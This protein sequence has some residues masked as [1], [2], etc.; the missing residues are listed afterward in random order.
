MEVK[1][2]NIKAVANIHRNSE[3][4][5]GEYFNYFTDYMYEPGAVVQNSAI[6]FV[7]SCCISNIASGNSSIKFYDKISSTSANLDATEKG[8]EFVTTPIHIL[9]FYNAI[10][11]NGIM[12]QPKLVTEITNGKDTIQQFHS[13]KISSCSFSKEKAVTVKMNCQ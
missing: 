11:N 4:I 9:A 10:A 3:G 2:G 7:D 13:T 8:Y 1:T 12:M 6:S 5:V